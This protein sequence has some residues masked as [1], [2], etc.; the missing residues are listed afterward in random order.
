MNAQE[1]FDTNVSE[2]T[3]SVDPN[4]TKA[5]EN[6]TAAKLG[7]DASATKADV[8]INLLPLK[9][10]VRV[11][12]NAQKIKG[13]SKVGD[14]K[15]PSVRNFSGNTQASKVPPAAVLSP[16]RTSKV[17]VGALKVD[18]WSS[19][20]NYRFSALSGIY[21]S[22]NNGF[23]VQVPTL[24]VA[25]PKVDFDVTAPQMGD[26]SSAPK[27]GVEVPKIGLSVSAPKQ[28]LRN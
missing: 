26:F 18:R 17:E 4:A 2:P 20:D 19:Y 28:A 3:K 23:S 13:D 9:V 5:N 8:G 10:G 27:L 24:N 25:A 7:G 11:D 16:Q 22:K 21:D 14:E 15:S 6:I 12:T 1:K